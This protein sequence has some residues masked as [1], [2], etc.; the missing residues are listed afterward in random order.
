MNILNKRST[1]MLVNGGKWIENIQKNVNWKRLLVYNTILWSLLNKWWNC[2]NK[3]CLSWF[4][5]NDFLDERALHSSISFQNTHFP[6]AERWKQIC[7]FWIFSIFQFFQKF[8][9]SEDGSS[10]RITFF[11]VMFKRIKVMVCLWRVNLP[12]YSFATQIPPPF[13]WNFLG[14]LLLNQKVFSDLI[15]FSHWS[16]FSTCDLLSCQSIQSYTTNYPN[17]PESR[18]R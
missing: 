12:F 15:L 11:P 18:I 8:A 13:I 17:Q 2:W 6:S 9:S 10:S 5:S 1:F 7:A 14:V 4:S 3:F 16:L